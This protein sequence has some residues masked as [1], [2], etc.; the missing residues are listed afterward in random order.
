MPKCLYVTVKAHRTN[1]PPGT[2]F[3][4]FHQLLAI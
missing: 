2:L 3:W 4:V 1:T